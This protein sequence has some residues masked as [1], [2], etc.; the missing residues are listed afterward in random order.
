MPSLTSEIIGGHSLYPLHTKN[1]SGEAGDDVTGLTSAIYS[2][3][4]NI[5]IIKCT[6][7]PVINMCMI[8]KGYILYYSMIVITLNVI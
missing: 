4:T 1:C 5:F 7:L 2:I 3:E 6:I 8:T